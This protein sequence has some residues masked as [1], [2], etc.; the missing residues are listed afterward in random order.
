MLMFLAAAASVCANLSAEFEK[1]EKSF[2]IDHYLLTSELEVY[3]TRSG[4]EARQIEDD[5]RHDTE[6]YMAKGDRITTLL[7]ANKCPPPDHVTSPNTYLEEL[8]AKAGVK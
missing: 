7:L 3:Q 5:L 4:P 2:A 8:K 1:N 6:Q